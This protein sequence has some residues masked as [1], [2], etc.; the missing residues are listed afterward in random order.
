MH[1]IKTVTK[2]RQNNLYR[3]VLG[4]LN[5]NLITNKSYFLTFQIKDNL[6]I[7]QVSRTKLGNSFPSAQ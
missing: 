3:T 2:I 5:I 7:L 6:D 1:L 4:Q